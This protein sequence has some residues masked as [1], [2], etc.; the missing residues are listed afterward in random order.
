M[1]NSFMDIQEEP[2]MSDELAQSIVEFA[3]EQNESHEE[4]YVQIN[5]L[6]NDSIFSVKEFIDLIKNIK[7]IT[8]NATILGEAHLIY[9]AINRGDLH[10]DYVT[11]IQKCINF[12]KQTIFKKNKF[13]DLTEHQKDMIHILTAM[14]Y[15]QE[16]NI[17]REIL[18]VFETL[19]GRVYDLEQMLSG[20]SFFKKENPEAFIVKFVPNKTNKKQITK[21]DLKNAKDKNFYKETIFYMFSYYLESEYVF[22]SIEIDEVSHFPIYKQLV[23]EKETLRAMIEDMLFDT[24]SILNTPFILSKNELMKILRKLE[25]QYIKKKDGIRIPKFIPLEQKIKDNV[26]KDLSLFQNVLDKIDQLV[27]VITIHNL[28]VLSKSSQVDIGN[29]N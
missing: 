25:K 9:D 22:N 3:M 23:N 5:A 10:I 1:D 4:E 7:K 16:E 20:C 29:I 27:T 8:K 11:I 18:D 26:E 2:I 13:I 15:D 19:A 14:A 24:C 28:S 21:K 6:L 17:S 12:E